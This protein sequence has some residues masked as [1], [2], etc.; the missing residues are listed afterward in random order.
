[1][2]ILSVCRREKEILGRR[3]KRRTEEKRGRE[4][5]GEAVREN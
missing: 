4:K 2:I 5:E 1:L 3:K